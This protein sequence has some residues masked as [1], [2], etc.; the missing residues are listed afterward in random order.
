MRITSSV[1][2]NNA[3]SAALASNDPVSVPSTG[4]STLRHEAEKK[5]ILIG[6]GAINPA[7]LEDPQFATVLSKHS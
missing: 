7:Y 4:T 5:D 6:S 3:F 2:L 1:V